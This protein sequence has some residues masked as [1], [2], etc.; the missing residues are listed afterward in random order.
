ML[1][2]T[3]ESPLDC[4]EIK[5]VSLKI[6][7][8]WIFIGRTNAKAEALILCLLMQ[9]ANLLKRTWCW[10][11]LKA[12]G[13]GD[14]RGWDGWMALLIQWI[15]VWAR[16]GSGE[17]QGHLVCCSPWG[18][19]GFDTTEWLNSNQIQDSSQETITATF[20]VRLPRGRLASNII[21]TQSA[22]STH[23]GHS[24]LYFR[25]G[26]VLWKGILIQIHR[27]EI[28]DWEKVKQ[29]ASS[30]VTELEVADLEFNPKWARCQSSEAGI[31]SK[32]RM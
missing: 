29:V 30:W 4:N 8:S 18:H 32:G 15:W 21:L 3:L 28:G 7:Q 25:E 2:K 31:G 10:D 20:E 6:N 23:S 19:Q 9:R 26:T 12:G 1:E 13:E 17:R 16:S 14:N 11:R 27:R 24:H 5:P 22:Y